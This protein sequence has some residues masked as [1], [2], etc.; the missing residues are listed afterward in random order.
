MGS[1]PSGMGDGWKGY[2]WTQR[3]DAALVSWSPLF[4]LV[5]RSWISRLGFRSLVS[6]CLLIHERSDFLEVLNLAVLSS[7]IPPHSIP[8]HPNWQLSKLIDHLL[9]VPSRRILSRKAEFLHCLS[10]LGCG[11]QAASESSKHLIGKLHLPYG[12]SS[13]QPFNKSIVYQKFYWFLLPWE[14]V[15][16]NQTT[17]LAHSQKKHISSLLD[18]HYHKDMSLCY[19]YT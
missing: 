11:L 16:L 4:Y 3:W 7:S 15:L 17:S 1:S 9:Q 13:F 5:P 14:Y 10:R 8:P 2:R 6:V 18:H 12:S 19:P